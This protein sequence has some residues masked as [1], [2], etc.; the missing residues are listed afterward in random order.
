MLS[1][2]FVFHE[3]F[4]FLL[5]EIPL[6]PCN[7]NFT[8]FPGF[9]KASMVYGGFIVSVSKVSLL[10]LA[11]STLAGEIKPWR[12]VPPGKGRFWG[13]NV[14][15]FKDLVCYPNSPDRRVRARAPGNKGQVVP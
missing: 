6:G 7:Y 12:I 1:T 4:S 9:F 2:R 3:S 10:S 8:Q 15:A 5:N 13:K 11:N 14:Y